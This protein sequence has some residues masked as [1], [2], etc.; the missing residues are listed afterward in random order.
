LAAVSVAP[1]K[2]QAV[3]VHLAVA[4]LPA[5]AWEEQE[6]PPQ[7]EILEALAV[8]RTAPLAGVAVLM[9]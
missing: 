5:V 3:L 4:V 6:V 2:E 7:R 1:I 8:L 9:V